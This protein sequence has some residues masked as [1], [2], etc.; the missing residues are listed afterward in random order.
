MKTTQIMSRNFGDATVL[1]RTSDSFFNATKMLDYF[2]EKNGT[3]KRFK[4]FWENQ[5][6]E[7]FC[8]A[9]KN[10]LISNGDNSAHYEISE[11]TRGK[12]GGTWMHPYLFVKLCF[13]LSPEFE[14]K[15]IK[16]VYDNLIEFRLQA[17]DHYTEMAKTIAET[18]KQ[19]FEKDPDPLVFIKEANYINL[20]VFGISKGKHRNEA[21][22]NE[23]NLLNRLQ[24][25]NIDLLKSITPKEKRKTKLSD[26]AIMFKTTSK[27]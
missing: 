16:F 26:F 1:Q 3:S 17:G 15:V 20:L 7:R 19:W 4:D 11:S 18:Y 5:N 2:N 21:T 22:E 6:T 25:L 8:E 9:L 14:V 23:L 24:L 10:E 12:G 27:P 13:W